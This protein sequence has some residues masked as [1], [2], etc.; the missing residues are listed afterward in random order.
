MIMK[1]VWISTALFLL[2]LGGIVWNAVYIHQSGA[3]LSSTIAA[4]ESPERR[5]EALSN[6]EAFWNKH[7]SLF[8]LSVSFR[9][10][11]HFGE[12]LTQLRWAHDRGSEEDFQKYR[13]LLQDAVEEITRNEQCFI[14]NLF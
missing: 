7:Q 8:G 11:D 13:T 6:V 9:E 14:K 5:E 10:L 4:M 3:Y 1:V 2:M 12:L